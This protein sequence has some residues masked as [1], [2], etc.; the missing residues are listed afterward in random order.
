MGGVI[1]VR[2]EARST[3]PAQAHQRNTGKNAK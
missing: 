1:K 3:F 2:N